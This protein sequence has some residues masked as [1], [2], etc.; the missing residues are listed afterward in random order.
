MKKEKYNL[1]IVDEVNFDNNFPKVCLDGWKTFLNEIISLESTSIAPKHSKGVNKKKVKTGY[2]NISKL[3]K[4]LISNL[5]AALNKIHGVNYSERYWNILIGHWLRRFIVSIYTNYSSITSIFED[6]DIQAVSIAKVSKESVIPNDYADFAKLSNKDQYISLVSESILIFLGYEH[7]LIKSSVNEVNKSRDNQIPKKSF[8]YWLKLIINNISLIF[9]KLESNNSPFITQTYMPPINEAL[10]N[11]HYFNFPKFLNRF[12]YKRQ[13]INFK[14]RHQL[15][16]EL[17]I[18]NKNIKNDLL[19]KIL[20]ELISVLIP[21]AYLED[22]ESIVESS[23]M[24]SLPN[25]PKFILTANRFLLDEVFKVWVSKKVEDGAPYYV[26]Q[27]GSNYGEIKYLHPTIEEIT[28][29]KFFTW[30]WTNDD[31]HIKGFIQKKLYKSLSPRKEASDRPNLLFLEK[32]VFSKII[33]ENGAHLYKK[34]LNSKEEFFLGINDEIRKN[35]LVRPHAVTHAD[36]TYKEISKWKS[37]SNDLK[38]EKSNTSM[39]KSLSKA[40]IVVCFYHGTSFLEMLASNFPVL[41]YLDG[42]NEMNKKGREA[43]E[44]LISAGICHT[45]VDSLVQ[46]L[47]L[48]WDDCFSWWSGDKIQ[49]ARSNFCSI[50]LETSETPVNDLKNLIDLNLI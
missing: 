18:N 13:K 37:L 17:V 15:K 28:C 33:I 47:N 5:S 34:Y 10:L 46:A 21:K 19:I 30:G 23:E 7:L 42:L 32:G 50:H 16:N 41:C 9:L 48:I 49:D 3:E 14:F 24:S 25:S 38:I 39:Y 44:I 36:K 12:K 4:E 27:H 26:L 2:N 40:K 43:Y 20:I 11:I 1:N 6:Y 22:Y 29:D 31:K 35:L 8:S 45:S